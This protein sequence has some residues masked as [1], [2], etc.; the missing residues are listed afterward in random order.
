[1]TVAP[2]LVP[3][4]MFDLQCKIL[5]YFI[6]DV[7]KVIRHKD[8][9]TIVTIYSHVSTNMTRHFHPFRLKIDGQLKM[10]FK[11]FGEL[12]C[13]LVPT[14]FAQELMSTTLK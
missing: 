10:F 6:F 7:L 14:Q 3:A 11:N 2:A 5:W 13:T 4:T 9:T 1:M 8:I 12:N